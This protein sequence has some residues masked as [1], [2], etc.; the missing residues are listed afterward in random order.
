MS[1]FQVFLPGF[2]LPLLLAQEAISPAG[3]DSFDWRAVRDQ[4]LPD[5]ED[6]EWRRI[7]WRSEFGR[8]MREASELGKLPAKPTG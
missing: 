4:V 8:A 1:T 7:P 6:Q 3:A 5:E 2:L